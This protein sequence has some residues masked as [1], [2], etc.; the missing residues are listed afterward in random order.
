M[1]VNCY[2]TLTIITYVNIFLTTI[3]NISIFRLFFLE[4]AFALINH[5]KVTYFCNYINEILQI[6]LNIFS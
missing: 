5:G 2:F 6:T 3:L 1:C 4:C